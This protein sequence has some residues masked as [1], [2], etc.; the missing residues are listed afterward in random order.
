MPRKKTSH[1]DALIRSLIT[2]LVRAEKIKTTP[3]RARIIKSQFDK[4]VTHAKKNSISGKK[5]VEAFF[6]S[7]KR[8]LERFYNVIESNL[9]DRN[10]G[11]T[12]LIK[13]LPRKGDGAEQTFIILVNYTGEEKVSK[14]QKLIEKQKKEDESKSIA[15]KVKKAVTGA[16][17]ETKT[18]KKTK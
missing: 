4:L 5:E 16:G 10:S 11:Y 2:E 3:T 13:T 14:G 12:H 18:A 6:G 8:T 1:R 7:N 9:S 15:G 17:R